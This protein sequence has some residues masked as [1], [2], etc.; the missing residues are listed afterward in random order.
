MAGPKRSEGWSA[1]EASTG[2]SEAS[3]YWG[4][5]LLGANSRCPLSG[6]F[7]YWGQTRV[8]P[9]RGLFFTGGKLALSPVGVFFLLRA[10]SRCPLSFFT[11]GLLGGTIT[12][13]PLLLCKNL[14]TIPPV[15]FRTISVICY[16]HPIHFFPVIYCA[17]ETMGQ[18]LSHNRFFSTTSPIPPPLTPPHS[19]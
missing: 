15:L 1:S 7:F 17:K 18:G 3:V 8:V 19:H 2:T 11:G 10:I 9:C 13:L 5:F 4:F 6:S 14:F 12:V 16:S